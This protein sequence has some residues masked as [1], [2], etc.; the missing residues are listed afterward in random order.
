MRMSHRISSLLLAVGLVLTSL[1]AMADVRDSQVM[2]TQLQFNF[3]NATRSNSIRDSSFVSQKA[4]YANLSLVDTTEA[5]DLRNAHYR[6]YNGQ[7]PAVSLPA[8]AAAGLW[9]SV[10]TLW[11]FSVTYG[12]LNGTARALA[13]SVGLAIQFSPDGV[14]W[15]NCDSL[16]AGSAVGTSNAPLGS[17]FS[18][19]TSN[20][21]VTFDINST[22]LG[23]GVQR[24]NWDRTQANFVRFILREDLNAPVATQYAV[25]ITSKRLLPNIPTGYR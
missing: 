25:W 12:D 15:T 11:A 1:P 16:G 4:S 24:S 6:N 2:T 3:R 7:L 22:M 20:G 8:H 23:I 18:N 19:I 17:L 9:S 13:D 5:F 21:R 14:V 10:D